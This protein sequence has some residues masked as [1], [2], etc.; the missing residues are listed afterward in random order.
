M[1]KGGHLTWAEID[2][3]ALRHNYW[4]LKN[5]AAG[6]AM[7]TVVKAD[8]YG[9]G[10]IESSKVFIEEGVSYLAVAFVTEG[11]E[12]RDAAIKTPILVFARPNEESIGIQLQNSLDVTVTDPDDVTLISEVAKKLSLKARVHLNIDTGMSR[13][14]VTI[15]DAVETAKKIAEQEQL[16][17]AGIYS[18]L[19][20][21]DDLDQTFTDNQYEKF[22]NIVDAVKKEG[23]NPGLTHISNS[24]G[25]LGDSS[26]TFDMVRPGIALY[27]H[28]PNPGRQDEKELIQ[29]MTLKSTVSQLRKIEK[30]SP[31]SY[32]QRWRAKEK[33]I[34]ATIPIGYADGIS[35]LLSNNMEVLIGGKR[36]PVVG[37]I[38][39]DMIMVDVGNSDVKIGD[40]VV[41]YG[42][43]ESESIRIADVALKLNTIS[44]EITCLISKR[45][46]RIYVNK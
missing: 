41:I 10:V 15:G 7:M 1:S 34:I 3:G 44:Y 46:P 18:H 2:V 25:L 24:G 14:G 39:M 32:G 40:E 37:T 33:T 20:S 22:M 17:F 45:V 27:G 26:R 12:L 11:V 4:I 13:L 30:E 36:Y 8:A 23:I 35:R 16:V 9:H 29:V 31:V 21:S 19:S 28:H 5:K 6:A 42:N 38:T 43:Q